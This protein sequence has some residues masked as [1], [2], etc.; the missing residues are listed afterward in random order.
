MN[1]KLRID[2]L[3]VHI[4]SLQEGFELLAKA[5]TLKEL[6]RLFFHFLRGTLTSVDGHILFHPASGSEWQ[7]LY[8]K[9]N[10]PPEALAVAG[11]VEKFTVRTFATKNASLLV[12]QPLID[13]A[14]VAV[15]LGRKLNRA[16]YSELDL[17]T[18]RVFLQLFANAYQ[19]LLHRQKEKGMVFS[20]NHRLLQL[21]S[22]IDTGIELSRPR[23]EHLLHLTALQRA[24]AL[25]NAS[26]GSVTVSRGRERTEQIVFP[27]GI[28]Y[29]K[30]ADASHRIRSTFKFGGMTYAFELVE[31]E[32]RSGSGPFDETDRMLLDALTRQVHAVLENRHLQAQEIEKQK[33]DRDIKVAADIQQRILPK[34]LPA[35]E[36]YDLAG[37]NIPTKFVGG[38]YYDCILLADG[39]YM[40]I[41]A[42]VAGKG[43]PAALLVSSFHAYLSAYLESHI[44]LT[45]LAR[46]LN[47]VIYRAST[48]ER[49][50]TAALVLFTPSTGELEC[51][52]AGHTATYL[53]RNDGTI[54]ELNTGGV[55]LG[56][57]DMDL[58]YKSDHVVLERGERLLLYTDGV[59]EAMNTKSQLYDTDGSFK[60][61]LQS[62]P[63]EAAQGIIN[64]LLADIERFTASAPQADD[65]T[66]MCLIRT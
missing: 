2:R 34:S 58:P 6:A 45:D 24:A 19:M 30:P 55:A 50:I 36:G 41:M 9:G 4:E 5:T 46:R 32:S 20:L 43:I 8:G 35:I 26:R 33:L 16:A 15:V 38:D 65:I 47:T 42:D 22:L 18:L 27:E 21:N 7:Q 17:I 48:E 37:V 13:R 12:I 25:T 63:S 61:F 66:A 53:H 54:Q 14:C 29:R 64:S 23:Q 3:A 1:T 28:R 57:L 49:Y 11:P 31:K 40:L 60:R 44:T 62:R 52:N 56:M 59:T 39:R 51:I 10:I